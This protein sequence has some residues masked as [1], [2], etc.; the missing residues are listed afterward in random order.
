MIEEVQKKY[1]DKVEQI[2]REAESAKM[3]AREEAVESIISKFR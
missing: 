3:V 2:N 1:D